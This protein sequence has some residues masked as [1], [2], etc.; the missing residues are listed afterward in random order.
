MSVR[1]AARLAWSSAVA[2]LALMSLGNSLSLVAGS[3]TWSESGLYEVLPSAFLL[4]Y[5]VIGALVA[6]RHPRNPVGWTLCGLS[7]YAGLI[8]LAEGYAE[9]FL[10]GEGGSR[11]WGEAAAWFANWSWAPFVLVPPTLL[12]LYFPDGR[13]P[14]RR[15]RL[16]PWCAGLGITLFTFSVAVEPRSLQDYP[17]VVNPYSIEGPVFRLVIDL[18]SAPLVLVGILASAASVVVRFRRATSVER[19]QIKWFTFAGCLLVAAIIVGSVI[20][21]WS[22]DAAN[23]LILVGLL[24]LPVALGAAILRYR[25]YDIDVVINRTLV[26]VTLTA[27]LALVYFGSVVL[28][29]RAFVFLTGEGSQLTVVVS[30]LTI[31]ALF[32]PLKRR[33]QNLI[34]R[35]LY[36]RKYDAQKTLSAFSEKLREETDLEALNAE[37]LTVIRETMQPEHVSLWLRETERKA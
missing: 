15:W 31:A 13:L 9:Y 34:D 5:S 22:E 25:L 19:Q 1:L 4:A 6:S 29:Q 3:L 35:R 26:Y 37:L 33:L 2:S 28:L 21:Y 17:S 8:A 10:A 12:L 30:T 24:G 16:V 11:G 36:R 7:L 14:S 18:V 20:S 23:A 27:T 32:V